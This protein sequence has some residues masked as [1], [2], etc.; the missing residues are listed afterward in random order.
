MLAWHGASEAVHSACACL[1]VKP[2]GCA[3]AH[4]AADLSAAAL[5]G[6]RRRAEGE[7]F[8]DQDLGDDYMSD[9]DEEDE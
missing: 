4:R 6:D 5:Y 2:C 7:E 9:F 8:D 3:Q 1:A